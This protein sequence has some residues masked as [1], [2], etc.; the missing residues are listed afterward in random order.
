MPGDG[1]SLAVR[2][3]SEVDFF[4]PLRLFFE[5]ADQLSFSANRNIVGLKVVVDIDSQLAFGQVAH[6]PHRG[7]DT[8]VVPQIFPYGLGLGRRLHD[9]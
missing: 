9:Q 6:M 5:L 4:S 8:I 2:V 7:D 3:G 1:L